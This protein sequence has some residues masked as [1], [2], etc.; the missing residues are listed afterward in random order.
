MAKDRSKSDHYWTRYPI[1]RESVSRAGIGCTLLLKASFCFWILSLILSWIIPDSEKLARWT[2]Q[3][4]SVTN[5]SFGIT[6]LL[7]LVSII[8]ILTL[9]FVVGNFAYLIFGIDFFND[10][11]FRPHQG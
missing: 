7:A 11:K 3:I 10:R 1:V 2:S 4:V 6:V 5:E 9:V 8:A